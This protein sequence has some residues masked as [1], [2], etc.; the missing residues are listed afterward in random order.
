MTTRSPDTPPAQWS[1]RGVSGCRGNQAAGIMRGGDHTS[2]PI[3]HN[4]GGRSSVRR[5]RAGRNYA[6]RRGWRSACG[7][8]GVNRKHAQEVAVTRHG[9]LSA[10]TVRPAVVPVCSRTR[11]PGKGALPAAS[12]S[13]VSPNRDQ[14]G[15]KSIHVI[16]CGFGT[17]GPACCGTALPPGCPSPGS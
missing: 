3:G 14:G 13:S 8:V 6:R 7:W 10:G 15:A 17:F 16:L 12:E 1:Q 5:S 2:G 11:I 4:L 9:S